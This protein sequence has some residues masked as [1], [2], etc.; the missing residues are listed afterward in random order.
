MF[1]HLGLKLEGPTRD[2]GRWRKSACEKVKAKLDCLD[3]GKLPGF[4]PDPDAIRLSAANP[5]NTRD[6]QLWLALMTA[7]ISTSSPYPGVTCY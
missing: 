5:F 2:V 4:T 7:P 1:G 3:L 6:P